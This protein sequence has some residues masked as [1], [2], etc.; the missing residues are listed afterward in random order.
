M[1]STLESLLGSLGVEQQE[2]LAVVLSTYLDELDQGFGPNADELVAAHPDLAGPLREYLGS[3]NLLQRAVSGIGVRSRQ[4]LSTSDN[5]DRQLGDYC[6]IREIG[7]GGMG[8]VYEARQLSLGRTVALKLLPFAAL[9]DQKQIARFQNEAQAA[10]GLHHPNIVSVFAVGCE[11]GVHFYS[12]QFIDGQSLARVVRELRHETAADIVPGSVSPT[13]PTSRLGGRFSTVRSVRSRNYVRAATELTVQAADALQHAHECGVVHRDVKPSNLLV[14]RHGKLWITDFG[15]ARCNLGP[16][17]TVTGDVLGTLRYISPEQATGKP[18]LVDH[19]TDVYSLGV[20]L[21]ELLALQP[22]FDGDERT[23]VLRRIQGEDPPSLRGLNPAVPYDLETIVLKAIAKSRE[24]R[25]PSA[26]EF[27]SDL[28]RFLA[29]EPAEARRPTIADRGIKWLARHKHITA[30][31]ISAVLLALAG[32][33]V[34]IVLLAAKQAET[35]RALLHARAHFS[36]VQKLVDGFGAGVSER[37]REVPGAE[38]VRGDLLRETLKYY[39]AILNYAGDTASLREDAAKAAFKAGAVH[40]QI[41]QNEAALD[42]YRLAR[43]HFSELIAA[44]TGKILYQGDLAL[45][46][47]NLGALL[48]RLGKTTEAQKFLE[49][50]VARQI[51]LVKTQSAE[52]RF[53]RE[54]ALSQINLG[55]ALADVG[56][57]ESAAGSYRAAIAHLQNPDGTRPADANGRHR[58]ANADHNLS[59]L[60]ADDQPEEAER[61]AVEAVSLLREIDTTRARAD[62]A[63][64]LA[65][66]G[67]LVNR[68]GRVPE[69]VKVLRQAITLQVK[70]TQEAPLVVAYRLDLACTRNNLGQALM[71]SGDVEGANIEFELALELFERLITEFPDDPFHYGGLAGVINNLGMIR[72]RQGNLVGAAMAFRRAVELQHVACDRAPRVERYRLFLDRHYANLSRVLESLGRTDEAEQIRHRHNNVRKT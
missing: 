5:L 65:N 40:E 10:A 34:T 7:R 55:M 68:H 69:A 45:C 59:G 67:A 57:I 38:E 14:D 2:R 56:R 16:D 72:E 23:D 26:Q 32:V 30:A 47:N 49:S 22:A 43:D 41:G 27:G 54:L 36:E 50:A 15:L 29:G 42:M 33:S 46:E 20:T 52:P 3:L 63:L 17:L 39:E 58:L 48:A 24:D 9:L 11:R 13:S 53:R 44:P 1:K 61:L 4:E 28:R 19:R 12:M 60:I 18:H 31:S 62:L 70:L 64:A 66:L 71:D 25:Y 8:V 37:L 6:L 21:F 35:D 51:E